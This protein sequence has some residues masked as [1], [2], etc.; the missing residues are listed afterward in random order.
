MRDANEAKRAEA[1]KKLSEISAEADKQALELL[2]EEQ[3]KAF[4]KMK[5]EKF[6]LKRTPREPTKK[7]ATTT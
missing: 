6:E 5:G 3:S 1:S 4:E 7:P 2:T